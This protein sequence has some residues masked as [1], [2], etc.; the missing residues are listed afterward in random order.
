MTPWANLKGRFYI[1]ENGYDLGSL[2]Y[3]TYQE[4]VPIRP[5]DD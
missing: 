5:L 2:E 4:L 3:R 1:D